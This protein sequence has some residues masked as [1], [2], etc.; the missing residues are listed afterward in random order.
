MK[1]HAKINF[2]IFI[3]FTVV[4]A[5]LCIYLL[6]RDMIQS[7][8][9]LSENETNS[10]TWYDGML[11]NAERRIHPTESGAIALYNKAVSTVPQ[12]LCS[13]NDF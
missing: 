4:I 12:L 13:N 11:E 3:T 6:Q 1:R 5:T 7:H 9:E 2:I 10:N 8:N